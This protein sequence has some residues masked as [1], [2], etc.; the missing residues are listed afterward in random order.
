MATFPRFDRYHFDFKLTMKAENFRWRD[1]NYVLLRY[2]RAH[3]S[4]RLQTEVWANGNSI[5]ET[6]AHQDRITLYLNSRFSS[7]SEQILDWRADFRLNL[8]ITEWKKST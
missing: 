1:I 3:A 5:N 7:E 6:S 8:I 4:C 2:S